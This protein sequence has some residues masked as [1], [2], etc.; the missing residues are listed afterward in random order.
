MNRYCLEDG[1]LFLDEFGGWVRWEDVQELLEELAITKSQ[2]EV[3]LY[4]GDI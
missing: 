3:A 2:L 1:S 4:R